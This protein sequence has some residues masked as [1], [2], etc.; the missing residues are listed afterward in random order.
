MFL[1]SPLPILGTW[2]WI[3]V[4]I[5][6]SSCNFFQSQ[7]LKLFS[8]FGFDRQF[9]TY[10]AYMDFFFLALDLAS[11]FLLSWVQFE[12]LSCVVWLW[13]ECLGRAKKTK[14]KNWYLWKL[15]WVWFF[16]FMF[17]FKS[18]WIF[19][20]IGELIFL[21]EMSFIIIIIFS[22]HISFKCAN[23]AHHLPHK[24]IPLVVNWRD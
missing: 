4:S 14:L 11:L 15:I 8:P 24:H 13:L 10:I 23:N 7:N 6:L 12:L 1:E 16:W 20:L 19:F 18:I 5:V 21:F 9:I 22:C 17:K 2:I 3:W